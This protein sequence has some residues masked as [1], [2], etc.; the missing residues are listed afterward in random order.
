MFHQATYGQETPSAKIEIMLFV[1]ELCMLI[2]RIKKNVFIS[3][4]EVKEFCGNRNGDLIGAYRAV[5]DFIS[6]L[7]H[8]D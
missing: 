6:A 1:D 4:I 8:R 2:F 7:S 3:K 5:N